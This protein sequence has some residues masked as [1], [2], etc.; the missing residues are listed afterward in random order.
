[1]SAD[2]EEFER[3]RERSDAFREWFK[4]IRKTVPKGTWIDLVRSRLEKAAYADE[5]EELRNLLTMLLSD[6]GR[7]DEALQVADDQIAE[8]PDIVFAYTRKA[9][10]YNT[11]LHDFENALAC[12]ELGLACARRTNCWL[13]MT[14]GHKARILV[15]KRDGAALARVL[16]EIIAVQVTRD[17]PDIG[18]ERD[19][20]DAVPPGV[21]PADLLARYD[22]FCPKR[23]GDTPHEIAPFDE[24]E[25]GPDGNEI[26]VT[27]AR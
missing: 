22:A 2:R 10:I 8:T 16:E 7:Y 19:F 6:A 23:E 25:W 20:V 24:P 17:A 9:D 27:R 14:L 26:P 13:R 18:R 21:I 1:V 3:S 12:M 11:W 4:L 15:R 5:R